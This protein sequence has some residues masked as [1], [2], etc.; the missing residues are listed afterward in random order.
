MKLRYLGILTIFLVTSLELS[1]EAVSA[2][3]YKKRVEML[4]YLRALEP[5]VKNF[6]GVDKEGKPADIAPEPGKE[7]DRLVRYEELKRTFQEGLQYYF[8]QNYVSSYRRFLDAQVGTEKLLEELSQEYVERAEKM[9]KVAME[10]KNPNNP[11]DK[12]VVD[13]SIEYGKGSYNTKD[14]L[15]DRESPFHR[16]MYEPR[17]FH[18]VT[19]KYTI[20][21]NAELGYRF[22]GM[23]K[24]A[25]L[26]GMEI[27]KLLEKH[28]KLQP[29]H[30]KYRIEKYL[31][32]IN[33]ARDAKFNAVN[34]FK[35]KYPYDNYYLMTSTGKSEDLKDKDG[36]VV[37]GTPV[38]LEGTNYD[39]SNNPYIKMDRR[40][41]ANFDVR[42]PE[43][44]RLDY[45]DC[46]FRIHS[47]DTDNFVYL[48][49]DPERRK[50]LNV[51]KPAKTSGGAADPKK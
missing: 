7:G 38:K 4:T 22:L 27:D 26:D 29:S 48:R 2:K 30:R 40:L 8:E 50:E 39:F 20:E 28:Q 9:L 45:S 1:A 32:A 6:P 34:I 12:A 11:E 25:R 49:Y 14:M 16:R 17:E 37:P 51:Q 47:R 10:K 46:R 23:A 42:V 35:M 13:I 19:G 36:N 31:G 41:Q 24:E 33:L 43:E 15:E 5:M 21:N 44:F 3:A 18:Y